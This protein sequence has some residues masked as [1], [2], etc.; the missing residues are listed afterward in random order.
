MSFTQNNPFASS[1]FG[2][3]KSQGSVFGVPQQQQQSTSTGQSSLFGNQQQQQQPPGSSF[4]QS[5]QQ[6]PTT[7]FG[8]PAQ[9]QQQVTGSLFNQTSQQQ[10]QPSA[11]GVFGQTTQQQQPQQQ[12]GLFGGSLFGGNAQLANTNQ[13]QQTSLFSNTQQQPQ[14]QN[15]GLFSNSLLSNPLHAQAAV[16]AGGFGSS[17]SIFGNKPMQLQTQNIGTNQSQSG[18]LLA[19]ATKFNDLP[20][21]IKRALESVDSHIQGRVQISKD[22]HQ[23][24]LG[25]EP[26][27]GHELIRE[28]H[29]ELVNTSTTTRNDLHHTKDIKAKVEQAVQDIIVA[30][31]I[32]DGFRNPQGGP[33]VYLKDHAGFPLEYFVRIT[34]Q[35][36]ERLA[37]YK[38]TIEQIERKLSS[39]ASQ[40]Q[41]P[42]GISATLQAQHATFLSLAGKTATL[43]TDLQKIK[44]LYTQLWRAKTGSVRDP[45]NELDRTLETG[46]DYGLGEL[47]MK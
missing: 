16:P 36:K 17:T 4:G 41:T 40:A 31:R 10:Q 37:W 18:A 11:G 5:T 3:P 38:S 33:A 9:Q 34:E 47:N 26:T 43:D 12:S 44:M 21:E 45:F 30:T 20:D 25:D 19:R 27:K 14:Q 24:K 22:L 13:P 29:K 46:G 23:R 32:V 1:T 6:Q 35:M 28:V 39:S 7:V 8:Q 15:T 2:T 42:Q